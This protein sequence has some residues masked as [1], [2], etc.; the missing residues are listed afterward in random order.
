VT[1]PL[2]IWGASGHAKVLAEFVGGLGYEIVALF[3]NDA[4]RDSPLAGVPVLHGREGLNRWR[5]EHGGDAAGL[6]AVG[7]ARGADRLELQALLAASGCKPVAV[8]HPTAWVAADAR[9]GA[10]SQVLAQAFV[11]AGSSVGEACIVNTAA[12]VDHECSLGDGVH[13][14]PGATLTGCITVGDHAFVGAAAVV[15]P[16]LR[17]GADAVVGAGAVVT[18]DVPAGATVVGNPA[19]PRQ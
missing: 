4:G 13:V 11:G 17:I 14:A 6:V 12:S 2:V 7:G 3:D 19:R 1:R 15:L 9:I 5:A 16:R 10:G 8:V 18:R